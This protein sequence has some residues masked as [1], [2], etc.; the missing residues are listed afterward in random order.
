MLL[1]YNTN[2]FAHHRLEDAVVILA[3]LGYRSIALTIDY[4]SLDPFD[5]ALPRQLS[6][7]KTLLQRYG[8]HSVVETGARF[9][10]DPRRKHQ[11]T[12]LG[13]APE[14][15]RRLDFLKRAVDVAA[16]L[17]SD[18]VSFW[19]GA[20]ETPLRPTNVSTASPTAVCDCAATPSPGGC[21]SPSSRNRGCSSTRWT[22][23]PNCASASITPSSALP[24]ISAIS[25]VL[26]KSLSPTTCAAGATGSGTSTSRT[27]A[28]A[29]T[30]I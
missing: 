5:P 22:I 28:A 6:A 17:G 1:G 30:T 14:R 19:S 11:P 4:H 25:I 26:E 8:L 7:V 15:E 9:L 24:S 18:A 27:C 10:L 2:G 16:E 20:P 13:P 23:S 3:D 12:L 29:S 21:A